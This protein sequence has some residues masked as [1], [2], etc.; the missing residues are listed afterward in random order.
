MSTPASC[1]PRPDPAGLPVDPA[2]LSRFAVWLAGRGY[3]DETARTWINRVRCAHAH[4]IQDPAGVADVLGTTHSRA[5][6]RQALREFNR[7]R[8]AV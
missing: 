3:A 7:F 5:V 8:E 6:M 2:D 1:R 4:G